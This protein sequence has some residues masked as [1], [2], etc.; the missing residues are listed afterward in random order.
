MM[1]DVLPLEKNRKTITTKTC[2]LLAHL[3]VFDNK[4][5]PNLKAFPQ[6][7]STDVSFPQNQTDGPE[8]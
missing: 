3:L 1:A 8:S 4:G 7:V 6:S 5:L 2:K